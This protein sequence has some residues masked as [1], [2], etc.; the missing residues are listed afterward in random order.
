MHLTLFSPGFAS[1][2]TLSFLWLS[3]IVSIRLGILIDKQSMMVQ[4][5]VHRIRS[6]YFTR[7]VIFET[8]ID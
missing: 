6:Q 5:E 7:C 3:K 8:K 1:D 4:S 2:S